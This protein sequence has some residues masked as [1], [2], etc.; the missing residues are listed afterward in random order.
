MADANIAP[1]PPLSLPPPPWSWLG[2]RARL[3]A[4]RREHHTRCR[5]A[6]AA[7]TSRRGAPATLDARAYHAARARQPA[8]LPAPCRSMEY[9]TGWVKKAPTADAARWSGGCFLPDRPAGTALR[10]SRQSGGGACLCRLG[11]H[12]G[13][14]EAGSTGASVAV[15][16]AV[17]G[18]RRGRA[19]RSPRLKQCPTG[20]SSWISSHFEKRRS[21]THRRNISVCRLQ[22]DPPYSGRGGPPV[23]RD[24]GKK[25]DQVALWLAHNAPYCT[26]S[27]HLI[28]PLRPLTLLLIVVDLIGIC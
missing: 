6:A 5:M 25:P 13:R 1:R 14:R 23:V 24:P 27:T 15:S 11:A 12:G 4:P 19:A 9:G 28:G 22:V 20:K 21:D 18:C 7:T 17:L 10:T 26:E 16:A 8:A 3:A 2:G